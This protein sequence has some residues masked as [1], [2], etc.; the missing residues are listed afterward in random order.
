MAWRSG[1]ASLLTLL[2]CAISLA[3]APLALAED[4]AADLLTPADKRVAGQNTTLAPSGLLRVKPDVGA[5]LASHG[6][7]PGARDG[8]EAGL[9][10]AFA[11]G[12]PERQPA[13]ATDYFQQILYAYPAGSPNRLA[14][15]RPEIQ[16]AVRRMNAVL[17]E[18]SRASGGPSADLKVLCD[19]QGAI[20]VDGFQAPGGTFAEIVSG[21]RAAGFRSP[22]AD[23]LIFYDGNLGGACGIA[24]YAQDERLSLD[25]ESNFGG[26]YAA[27]YQG[28]WND[29][30]PLHE[31]GHTMGAVQYSAPNST[32]SGGHCFGEDDVMCYSPDGGDLNQGGVVWDCA[33]GPRFDC[34]FDDYFDSAP[35]PGEYLATHWNLGSPLNRFISFGGVDAAVPGLGGSA[36]SPLGAGGKERGASGGA[37]EWR[38]FRLRVGSHRNRLRVRIFAAP[39]AD[40]VLY[41][42]RGRRPT[43]SAFDCRRALE[44]RHASCRIADARPGVWY[45]GVMTRGG[46][47]GAAY[48]LRVKT[49]R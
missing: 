41:L 23:Y 31:S 38:H 20:A 2:G 17:D 47:V 15:L 11:P 21:A 32:G 39:Q 4:R 6:P 49:K 22:V 33:G 37:G 35:E 16:A 9:G 26:G 8:A 43:R 18:Q 36:E 1:G 14:E 34:N 13:C 44:N 10:S 24:T 12:A 46:P 7:D 30:T 42:R 19:A 5:P 3:L 45:A 25:N 29:E 28:C 27:V 48:K 40:L